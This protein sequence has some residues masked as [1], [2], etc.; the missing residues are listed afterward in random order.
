[1]K[2]NILCVEKINFKM[3]STLIFSWIPVIFFVVIVLSFV[4]FIVGYYEVVR[5]Y[6]LKS[7][8]RPHNCFTCDEKAEM[9]EDAKMDWKYMTLLES[10][11]FIVSRSEKLYKIHNKTKKTQ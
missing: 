3:I 2:L 5:I 1:M 8:G 11:D 9:W 7:G 4:M 6:N 10:V